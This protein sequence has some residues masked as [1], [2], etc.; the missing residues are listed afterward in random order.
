MCSKTDPAAYQQ[1]V[2][3]QLRTRVLVW[4]RE[5]RETN[6]SERVYGLVEIAA[7]MGCTAVE[8]LCDSTDSG[9]L[10]SLRE[11]GSVGIT[12]DRSCA[13]AQGGHIDWD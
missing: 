9:V 13:F 5:Q 7:A 3:D 4:L 8:L 2:P 11:E 12:S 10:L 6:G 1:L